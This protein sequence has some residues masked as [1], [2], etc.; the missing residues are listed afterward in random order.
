VLDLHVGD[1]DA[2]GIGLPVQQHAL[3]RDGYWLECKYSREP[4]GGCD[5]TAP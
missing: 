5:I 1:L 4:G 2:P 3:L